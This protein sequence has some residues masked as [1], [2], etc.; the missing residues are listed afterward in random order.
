MSVRFWWVNQPRSFALEKA[1]GYVFADNPLLKHHTNVLEL[2]RGDIILHNDHFQIRAV[3]Q[4]ISP[5]RKDAPH[6][7]SSVPGDTG[8]EAQIAYYCLV[9]PISVSEIPGKLRTPRMG[10]FT[11]TGEPA[12]VYLMPIEKTLVQELVGLNR[13]LW[14]QFVH[15]ALG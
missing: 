15:D 1:G 7:Y 4:V 3:S 10:P 5:G 13:N 6:R 2:A 11:K 9:P 14:P 8:Y 12:H